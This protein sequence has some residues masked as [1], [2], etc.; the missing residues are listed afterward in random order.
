MAKKNCCICGAE[1]GLMSQVQLADRELMCRDCVKKTS[2]F[3]V[4][5][6]RT[7]YDYKEHMKQ[8]ENGKKL[9]D[10]YFASNKTVEK[11]LSKRVLVDK[12]TGL[13]C[14]TERRG[15]IVIWGGTPFYTVFRIADLD[16]CEGETRFEKG[17]DGKNVEKF[18]VHFTFRNVLGLYDIR[19]Q[20]SKAAYDSMMK[21]LDKILGRA[22]IGSIK[23]GFKKSQADAQ[24]A[25]AIAG[26][27]KNMMENKDG[28]ADAMHA[29]AAEIAG[30]MENSF[31]NGREELVAKA[32]AAIKNVLG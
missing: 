25:A 7:T 20:S 31:Y 10:A 5:L 30:A 32:D 16:I 26:S 3:F 28:G 8:L 11:F 4:P 14:I 2:P 29:D 21:Y 6:E 12:N 9:Y 23:A 13:M 15:K 17:S 22:G 27:L 1:I 24:T 18:D 19:M